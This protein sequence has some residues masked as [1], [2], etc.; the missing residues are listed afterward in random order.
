M[1]EGGAAAI[2][3]SK[4]RSYFLFVEG[5]LS[6]QRWYGPLALRDQGKMTLWISVPKWVHFGG[7]SDLLRDPHVR[8]LF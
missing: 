4:L 6:W 1:F 3:G 2:I 7:Y 8:K 5:Q